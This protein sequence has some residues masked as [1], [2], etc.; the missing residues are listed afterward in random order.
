MLEEEKQVEVNIETRE[1]EEEEEL[2]YPDECRV[3][4]IMKDKYQDAIAFFENAT[5][6]DQVYLAVKEN[7]IFRTIYF[8]NMQKYILFN[9]TN[10]E[11]EIYQR[12]SE[13]VRSALSKPE[14]LKEMRII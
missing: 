1:K 3:M 9:P 4:D 13:P 12:L 11:D 5:D 14:V 7:Q 2:K 10:I 6:K 8:D